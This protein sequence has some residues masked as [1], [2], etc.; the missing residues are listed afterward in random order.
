M[1]E[2]DPNPR[3]VANLLRGTPATLTAMLHGLDDG[4]LSWRPAPGEWCIKEVIGHLLEM[5]T[6]AF[7]D[8]IRLILT[9]DKPEIPGIDVNRIAAKRH[10]DQRPLTEL[11]AAFA[12][13]RETA[14]AFLT[15]LSS[16]Q[17]TRTGTLPV[18]RHFRAA[19]FVYEWPYHDHAHLRQICGIIQATVWPHMSETMQTALRG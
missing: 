6:L 2:M 8:R 11:M 16:D 4:L 9:E 12:Q 17:L 18:E 13:E 7:A 14:V 15:Q 10:D 5:D 1:T 19:D 3:A